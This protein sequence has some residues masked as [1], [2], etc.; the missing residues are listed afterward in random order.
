GND[1]LHIAVNLVRDDGRRASIHQSKRRTAQAGARVAGAL[2][3]DAAFDSE[4]SS[5]IGNASRAEWERSQK[6]QRDT[7]RV[8]LR[9]R[10]AAA[11]FGASSE[12]DFVRTAR[13]MGV[14]VR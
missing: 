10:L 5:G 8:L 6:Q 12:A 4:L 11:A 7:D 3:K 13:G 1:H 2:G 14:L 9:R